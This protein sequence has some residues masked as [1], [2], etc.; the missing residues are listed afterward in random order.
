[1]VL[2]DAPSPPS[3]G[4]VTPPFHLT[5][6]VTVDLSAFSQYIFHQA[7]V[8]YTTKGKS[9][10]RI[11]R[12]QSLIL[13]DIV[14]S[15]LVAI[16]TGLQGPI[17]DINE[18]EELEKEQATASFFD[19]AKDSESPFF[20]SPFAPETPF[21][22][23]TGAKEYDY[24]QGIPTEKL[25]GTTAASL[26]ALDRAILIV[27][28]YAEYPEDV[29]P[30]PA[31]VKPMLK[32]TSP[33]AKVQE[34]ASI[35][36]LT[37]KWIKRRQDKGQTISIDTSATN[38][39]TSCKLSPHFFI[40]PAH[41]NLA[42]KRA[43]SP[44]F[45]TRSAP[46][47]TDGK[48]PSSSCLATLI[49]P[50]ESVVYL[51]TKKIRTQSPPLFA[52][53]ELRTPILPRSPVYDLT[54]DY[55]TNPRPVYASYLSESPAPLTESPLPLEAG[56]QF[57]QPIN[58]APTVIDLTAESP[59]R[60]PPT[61]VTTPEAP[62]YTPLYP[63]LPTP[64]TANY[65]GFAGQFIGPALNMF[66]AKT[67]MGAMKRP[68]VTEFGDRL[69]PNGE[70][71]HK[72]CYP[73]AATPAWNYEPEKLSRHDP[74]FHAFLDL[75]ECTQIAASEELA[76][77]RTD[78]EEALRRE[79]HIELAL[80][81]LHG[82]PVGMYRYYQGHLTVE[83]YVDKGLCVCWSSCAC[84]KVCSRYGDVMCP[85]GG[86]LELACDSDSDDE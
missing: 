24:T 28:E 64:L 23:T 73:A 36:S 44:S 13:S 50:A 51:G 86:D 81:R 12:I 25:T 49:P 37:A 57:P 46:P 6:P 59:P 18:Q 21:D 53:H 20:P 79:A 27:G 69:H 63:Y 4:P 35:K 8:P 84:S 40:Q 11:S 10:R 26:D 22:Q 77:L 55:I 45:E 56:I 34:K 60:L 67:K 38:T 72:N 48:F 65:K 39:T 83:E 66:S 2:D 80:A 30:V 9:E 19:G 47:V 1:M 70:I 32:P 85:C 76:M 16:G 43:A 42:L 14:D 68:R 74:I 5:P 54:P 7:N 3:P 52:S 17:P 78:E 15:H 62:G 71:I 82:F 41:P 58:A 61:I 31:A 75:D 29:E 33:K